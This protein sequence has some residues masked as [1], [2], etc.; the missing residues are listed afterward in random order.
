MINFREIT[1]HEAM[2]MIADDELDNLYYDVSRNGK[3]IVCVTEYKIAFN[4]LNKVSYFK[5]EVVN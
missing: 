4:D 5:K 3:D 1:V 2:E